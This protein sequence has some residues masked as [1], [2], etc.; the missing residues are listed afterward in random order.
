MQHN[1]LFRYP[2]D[3]SVGRFKAVSAY[4]AMKHPKDYES[5][6]DAYGIWFA[7]EFR[8]GIEKKHHPQTWAYISVKTEKLEAGEFDIDVFGK[9]GKL[10]FWWAQGYP[11]GIIIAIDEIEL[12][13]RSRAV[14]AEKLWSFESIHQLGR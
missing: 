14:A 11:R 6:H 13:E 8:I 7:G 12:I 4:M 3:L 1:V 9:P 5:W 10:V 2:L